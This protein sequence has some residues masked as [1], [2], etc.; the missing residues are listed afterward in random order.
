M[1]LTLVMKIALE[2]SA[3]SNSLVPLCW[4]VQQV[5][6]YLA[7]IT[8][9]GHYFLRVLETGTLLPRGLW[10]TEMSSHRKDGM[11]ILVMLRRLN[12]RPPARGQTN[13][14]ELPELNPWTALIHWVM[15]YC[16]KQRACTT[17]SS[18]RVPPSPHKRWRRVK[19]NK[20]IQYET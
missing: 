18:H 5:P 13:T 6:A 4:L 16:F 11:S 10:D 19:N 3:S 20:E 12:S 8:F 15:T 17:V 14:R 9:W 2:P 7:Q 1:K